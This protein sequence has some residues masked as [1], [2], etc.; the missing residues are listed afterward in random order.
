MTSVEDEKCGLPGSILCFIKKERWN[1]EV[2]SNSKLI[3]LLFI[4]YTDI[5][6]NEYESMKK[7]AFQV[8]L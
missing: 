7:S 3:L 4:L 6:E 8:P 1:E 5:K 2:N